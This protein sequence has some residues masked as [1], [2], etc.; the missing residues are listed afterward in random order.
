MKGDQLAEEKEAF[1]LPQRSSFLF[2][3]VIDPLPNFKAPL[4]FVDVS[5]T[6]TLL[7]DLVEVRQCN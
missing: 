4:N 5:D 3:P 6:K 1:H 2:G 7:E